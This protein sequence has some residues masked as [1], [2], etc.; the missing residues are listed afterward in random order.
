MPHGPPESID[1]RAGMA[2]PEG[3]RVRA[4]ISGGLV[5]DLE[6]GLEPE[7][8]VTDRR[9]AVS[10]GVDLRACAQPAQAMNVVVGQRAAGVGDPQLILGDKKRHPGAG[11]RRV[12]HRVVGALKQLVDKSPPIIAGD[13]RLLADIFQQPR[14]RGTVDAQVLLDD[15]VDD[16]SAATHL[17]L[18]VPSRTD[19]RDEGV[20]TDLKP[21]TPPRETALPFVAHAAAPESS[22]TACSWLVKPPDFSSRVASERVSI[23]KH[24][25]PPTDDTEQRAELPD[26]RS[27]A[28]PL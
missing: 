27:P 24:Q 13:L 15:A 2:R 16:V 20:L 10:R 22:T 12:G 11:R 23:V 18:T 28:R 19:W 9:S 3:E 14:V 21:F 6:H 1:R 17:L 8:L 26:H 25:T 7:T 5:G 4:R